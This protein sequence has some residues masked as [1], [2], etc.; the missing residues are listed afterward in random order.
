ME[1][2]RATERLQSRP[3]EMDGRGLIPFGSPRVEGRRAAT[4]VAACVIVQPDNLA[5]V[6]QVMVSGCNIMFGLGARLRALLRMLC[7]ELLVHSQVSY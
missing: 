6:A 5:S 1:T 2:C 3:A 4:S 7:R